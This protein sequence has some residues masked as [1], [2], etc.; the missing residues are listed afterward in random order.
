MSSELWIDL[1]NWDGLRRYAKYS[2][3][4]VA[5]EDFNYRLDIGSYSGT[6]GKLCTISYISTT[7]QSTPVILA[8]R[9]QLDDE[10][11]SSPCARE[12]GHDVCHVR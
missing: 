12:S 3:F 7:G 10:T 5:S 1:E 8:R 6:S 4:N 11:D 2:G 9:K